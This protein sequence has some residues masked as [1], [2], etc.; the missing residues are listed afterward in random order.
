[1]NKLVQL[2]QDKKNKAI[3]MVGKKIEVQVSQKAISINE[4]KHTATFVM[5]TQNIDRHGDIVDQNS[6]ITKYF[7]QNPAFFF[8]HRS[9]EFPLGRWLKVWFEA[10]PDNAGYNRMVG[11]A[12]F[13]VDIDEDAK[14]AW[15]HVK[16]GN[17]NMVS[18][19]FIPHRVE[20]DEEKD[21]FVLYD[22]E[23]IECSLVGIGSN[24]QAL[25]KD[26]EVKE[27][28]DVAIEAR[29]ELDKKIKASD[30]NKV[31]AHLKARE[32][33][34]KAIRRMRGI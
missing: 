30:T 33:L 31:I 19:G 21:A 2:L 7:E 12:Y 11:E 16:E 28:R 14:R 3:E 1:M 32:D 5:S 4:E 13:S 10:D 34:N 25:I 18:V 29:E 22:C 23:L 20:Y 24:R 6:W 8:Q 26:N 27:V 9:D 17:L 15:E